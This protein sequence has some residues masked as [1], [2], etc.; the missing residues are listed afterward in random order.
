ML[1][2]NLLQAVLSEICPKFR[3]N[4]DSIEFTKIGKIII[5][6]KPHMAF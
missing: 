2:T 4:Y 5:K 3:R 1:K 6:N